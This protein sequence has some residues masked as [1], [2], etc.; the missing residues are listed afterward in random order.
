[1]ETTKAKFDPELNRALWE[2]Y[3]TP[4]MMRYIRYRCFQLGGRSDREDIYQETLMMVY[5]NIHTYN[6]EY[7]L[8]PWL[9]KAGTFAAYWYAKKYRKLNLLREFELSHEPQ[10]RERKEVTLSQENYRDH[11]SDPIVTVL[12]KL[13]EYA[14]RI[15][16]LYLNGYSH[17]EISLM[18]PMK[19]FTRKG[20]STVPFKSSVYL[21]KQHIRNS[22]RAAAAC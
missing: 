9:K 15:F 5:K 3:I 12:D 13:S 18:V 4:A 14:R 8:I 11:F 2:K 21:T 19:N 20:V 6:P 1:M 17:P 10:A 22:M 7:P 16:L